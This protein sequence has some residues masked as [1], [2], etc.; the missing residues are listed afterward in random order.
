MSD[1]TISAK[2]GFKQ[3]KGT[4]AISKP[5]TMT[6]TTNAK[7]TV[8]AFIKHLNEE[9]FNAARRCTNEGMKFQGVLGTR[10][11]ADAYFEDM[12]HMKLKYHLLKTFADGE[13]VCLFYD[14]TMSGITIFSCGWYR[15][16]NNKISS[17]KVVF[18]PRP[19]LAQ[20]AK[21]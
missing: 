15:V 13:D 12:E 10:D 16:E 4:F 11:G 5:M 1:K 18:D 19:V 9:D 8:M 17:I 6:T 14:I 3:H 7:N 2:N 21:K 20:S